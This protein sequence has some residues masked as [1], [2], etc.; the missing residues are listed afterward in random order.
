MLLVSPSPKLHPVLLYDQ[1]FSRY[2]TFYN[3][4]LTTMLNS[5]QKRTTTT[6][7]TKMPNFKISNFTNVTTLVQT[8]SRSMHDFLGVNKSNVYFQMSCHLKLVLPYGPMLTKT[9]KKIVKTQLKKNGFNSFS[10]IREND[11]YGRQ[12][13]NDGRR[14]P[15]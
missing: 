8:F 7:T 12:R 3:S 11:V 15:A 10:G 4:P 14:M 5:P 6:T 13:D 9:K 2:C 1:P